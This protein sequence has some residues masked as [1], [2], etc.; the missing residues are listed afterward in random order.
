MQLK[1][2]KPFPARNATRTLREQ[3]RRHLIKSPVRVGDRFATDTELV[4]LTKLSKST[5]RRAMDQ[6]QKEGWVERRNGRGTFVGPRVAMESDA[7]IDTEDSFEQSNRALHVL[8]ACPL[9]TTASAFS[10]WRVGQILNTML[11]R[12]PEDR[13]VRLE[14][15][16]IRADDEPAGLAN[17]LRE[18]SPDVLMVLMNT[19][20][21]GFITGEAQ[22]I[23]IPAMLIGVRMPQLRVPNI[24]EDGR[25]GVRDAVVDLANRGHR[26]I[27]LL[28]PISVDHWSYDRRA[29]FLQGLVDA[30]LAED[31]NMVCAVSRGEVGEDVPRVHAYLDKQHPT[32]VICGSWASAYPLGKLVEVGE[33]RVPDDL[34]VVV[35]DQSPIVEAWLG[36]KPTTIGQPLTQIGERAVNLAFDL[37]RESGVR[38]RDAV[39]VPCEL[40]PGE[41]V[42]TLNLSESA[43]ADGTLT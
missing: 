2:D 23:G 39:P 34:S 24:F 16:T 37:A 13:G 3:L 32:A 28:H 22:R 26:R 20:Y 38:R 15:T 7:D 9:L 10:H 21:D 4:K 6:L 29:G 27:G 35:F 1:L 14:L 5:V 12:S 18:S 41:S 8:V 19:P 11:D 42:M 36:V 30:G 31:Q 43:V 40:L 17:R 33:V 25:Q